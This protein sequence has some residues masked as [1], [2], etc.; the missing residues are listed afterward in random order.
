LLITTEYSNLWEDAFKASFDIA[1]A[2][3]IINLF[4]VKFERFSP[5]FH[6][7]FQHQQPN[8]QVST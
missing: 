1:Q 2:F 7:N 4:V 5:D 3:Q 8:E 6:R